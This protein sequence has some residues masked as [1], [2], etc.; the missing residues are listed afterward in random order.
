MIMLTKRDGSQFILN[1][2]L[3]EKIETIP[4]TKI[5]LQSE[6][7]LLVLEPLGEVLQKI[8]AYKK[9]IQGNLGITVR[10]T[11]EAAD[12]DRELVK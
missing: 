11:T 6:R 9:E 5:T 12:M 1:C 10:H 7:F 4:E 3:I 8:I 2:D